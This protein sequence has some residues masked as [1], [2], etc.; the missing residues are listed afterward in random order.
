MGNSS[1]Q[2]MYHRDLDTDAEQPVEQ[3]AEIVA[4]LEE[5]SMKDLTPLYSQLDHVLDQLFSDPPAEEADVVISFT[6]ENYRITVEQ[7]GHAKFV[8]T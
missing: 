1:D 7:N 5:Q 3:I 2:E 8:E 4:D 6:Y